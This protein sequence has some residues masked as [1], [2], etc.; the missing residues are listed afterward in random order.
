SRFYSINRDS[1]SSN[2]DR[3]RARDAARALLARLEDPLE[4]MWRLIWAEPALVAGVK[5][6][7][8]LDLFRKW[9]QA[10]GGPKSGSDLAKLV[11]VD[12]ILLRRNIL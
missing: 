7:M 3:I 4:T 8:D 5:I 12:P 6:L 1:I 11:A 2:N 9:G 10:D